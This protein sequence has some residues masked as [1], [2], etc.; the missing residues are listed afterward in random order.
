MYKLPAENINNNPAK[1][2]DEKYSMQKIRVV[3]LYEQCLMDW[4]A[5]GGERVKFDV[6]DYCRWGGKKKIS[7]KVVFSRQRVATCGSFNGETR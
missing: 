4:A 3:A 1:Q 5:S 6:H 7:R 2:N